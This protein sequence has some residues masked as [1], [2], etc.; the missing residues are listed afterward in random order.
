[1]NIHAFR[2]SKT[3]EACFFTGHLFSDMWQKTFHYTNLEQEFEV[4]QRPVT[5]LETI[6]TQMS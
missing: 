6:L 5:S 4:G 2:S 1:M 3:H